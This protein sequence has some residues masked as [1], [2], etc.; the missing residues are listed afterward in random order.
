M[1][2]LESILTYN[3]QFVANQDYKAYETQD[4]FPAKRLVMLTCMDTRLVDLAT[5]A[6]NLANGDVKV[7]K[8]AGALISH[9]Y[10]SI[11]RSLVI[12]IYLLKA[13]E[14]IIMGHHD[15]GM[16]QVDTQA[17]LTKM[18]ERGITSENLA[19]LEAN[20]LNLEN[21]LYGF[22]DVITSVRHDVDLVRNHP[23]IPRDVPVHG[24][25]IDPHTGKVDLVVNGYLA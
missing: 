2:L 7:I 9:P 24:L 19:S 23:L 3:Q 11:M 8:N 13:D 25:V 4:K 17:V 12:A 18:K 10:G 15:C 6:L 20:G 16:Q 21:W 1:S 22:D 5:K 14:V